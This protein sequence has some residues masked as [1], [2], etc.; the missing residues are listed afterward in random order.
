MLGMPGNVRPTHKNYLHIFYEKTFQHTDYL[1]N[2]SYYRYFIRQRTYICPNRRSIELWSRG[3]KP[4]ITLLTSTY[5]NHDNILE[6]LR[7][8]CNRAQNGDRII[9]YFSGHGN[10]GYLLTSD[11]KPLY[12]TEIA[13]ILNTT[14]A[15]DVICFID[16][17][18][19]GTLA[20]GTTVQSTASLSNHDGHAYFVS[21]RPTETSKEAAW[22]GQGFFTQALLK[23]LRGKCDYDHNKEI[24]VLELFKYIHADVTRRSQKGQHPQL[25][26]P[27]GMHDKIIFDWKE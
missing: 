26:A 20:S 8:I 5:A 14:K 25:I 1:L 10:K 21:C 3:R 4:D 17:C 9:F 22:V 6:K 18:F 12:Y 27:K 7:A 13:N 11:I 15:S 2:T 23:G 24:T 19:A 16:A